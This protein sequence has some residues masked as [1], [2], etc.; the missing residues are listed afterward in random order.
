MAISWKE[1]T[2]QLDALYEFDREPVAEDKLQ[3]GWSSR[4]FSR[5]SMSRAPSS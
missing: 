3:K 2:A 4:R 5:A 1:I